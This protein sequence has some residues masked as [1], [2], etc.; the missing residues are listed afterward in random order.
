MSG[1]AGSQS[2]RSGSLRSLIEVGRDGIARTR[3][4]FTG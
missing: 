2:P 4:L 1:S 3:F